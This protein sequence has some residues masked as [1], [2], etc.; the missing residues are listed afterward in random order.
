MACQYLKG[1]YKQEWERLCTRSDNDRTRGN[2]FRLQEGTCWFNGI[3]GR[4]T[5]QGRNGGIG[6][7]ATGV[8]SC[9]P[10]RAV[11]KLKGLSAVL[12]CSLSLS[13]HSQQR[14]S[15]EKEK[16]LKFQ[17]SASVEL[18]VQKESIPPPKPFSLLSFVLNT[19][20]T[21]GVTND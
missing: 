4:A 14:P 5:N 12:G 19:H 6:Q 17:S 8:Q 7:E 11:C 16:L 1:A 9:L 21:F 2:D 20:Y 10:S 18:S 15:W 3:N 13:A